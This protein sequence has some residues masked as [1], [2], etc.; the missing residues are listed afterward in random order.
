MSA[1]A[2]KKELNAHLWERHPED[3]YVE[4]YWCNR[5]LFEEEAFEGGIWDPSCGLGRVLYSADAAGYPVTGSDIVCRSGFCDELFDFR[6][7]KRPRARNIV[8]NPPFSYAELFVRH[9]LGIADGKVAFL[10]PLQWLA[11]ETRARFFPSTPL[12]R[13]Y[14]LSPRPSMPP[15]PVI[16]ANVKPGGGKKDFAWYVW[17][18][19]YEGTPEL[20]FMHR[21]G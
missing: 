6:T 7:C 11:S 10:L 17:E 9:A 5:R 21:E 18:Q 4:P 15:G 2:E 1:V 13:V 3:W 12:R 19:G 14:I 16:E 8:S 20:K